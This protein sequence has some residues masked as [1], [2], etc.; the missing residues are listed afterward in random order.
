M[1][2]RM[3]LVSRAQAPNQHLAELPEARDV[4]LP[5]LLAGSAG[6]PVEWARRFHQ[7]FF[8]VAELCVEGRGLLVLED[9]VI[10]WPSPVLREIQLWGATI[11]PDDLIRMSRTD[12]ARQFG[13]GPDVKA[14]MCTEG[15]MFVGAVH[16]SP[17]VDDA[18]LR[19]CVT[20]RLL[21][22]TTEL[23]ARLAPYVRIGGGV[24]RAYRHA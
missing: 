12:I 6:A 19:K 7:F 1:S 10:G 2:V 14:G 3:G 24:V 8:D 23:L 13:L 11:E 4:L 5:E 22:N 18:D 17:R 15:L 9:V 21:V 20:A 16:S